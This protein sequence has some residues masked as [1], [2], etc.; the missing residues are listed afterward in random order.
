MKTE[1]IRHIEISVFT[2]SF[3]LLSH[4]LAGSWVRR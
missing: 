2:F 1:I 4:P 3:K